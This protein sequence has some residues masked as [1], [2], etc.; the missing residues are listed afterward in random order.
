MTSACMYDNIRNM[1]QRIYGTS[2]YIT[3]EQDDM[4]TKLSVVRKVSRSEVVRQ[5]LEDYF[6]NVKDN[7]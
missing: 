7:L 1:K 3:A 2:F 6:K 5:I 4:I